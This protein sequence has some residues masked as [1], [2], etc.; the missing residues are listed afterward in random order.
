MK[1]T[2]L[3]TAGPTKE[4]IDPVRFISNESTGVLGNEIARAARN[5]GC[6]VVVISG[7][8]ALPV[9]SEVKYVYVTSARELEKVAR[10]QIKKADVL[11][12]TSAVCDY[13][14]LNPAKNK[15]KHSKQEN[16]T[17]TLCPNKDILKSLSKSSIKANKVYI[18]FCIETND[19]IKNAKAKRV[20]KKL[21]LIVATDYSKGKVPFG[22]VSM[23]PI[24]IDAQNKVERMPPMTKKSIARNLV[25]RVLK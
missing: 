5:K 10:E 9:L 17:I 8:P 24:L 4:Y 12:M 16:L 11:F 15:I 19:V 14:P 3:I 20:A 18:G 21:D 25:N 13:R 7:N 1:K 23:A 2:I 22:N 6:E